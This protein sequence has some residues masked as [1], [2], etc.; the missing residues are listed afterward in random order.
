MPPDRSVLVVDLRSGVAACS[1][2][3]AGQGIRSGMPR[4]EAEA[5]APGAAVVVRDRG[6]EARRFEPLVSAVEALVPRVEVAEPG[7]MFVPV[8]GAVRYYGGEDALV[9]RMS[10]EL[11]ALASGGLIGLADGPFAARWAAAAAG[12]RT[13]RV[14]TDTAGFLAGLD[15]SLLGDADLASVF[16]W[17][18]VTTLGELARLP[19]EALASR[20]GRAGLLAHRLASGEDRMVDPRTI[21]A[22][23]AVEA[24][25]EEPLDT[26]DRAG[27]AARSLAARLVEGLGR[28][29]IAPHRVLVEVETEVGRV[30]SRVWRSVDPFTEEALAERVRW[31]LRAWLDTSGVGSGVVRLRL[32]PS[33]L[34]GAGRQQVFFDEVDGRIEAERALG[35]VQALVGPDAVLHAAPQGGRLPAEQVVWGRWGEDVPTPDRDPEAPWPGATPTPTP[36]LV[37]PEPIPLH[38][39]WE[40]GFPVAVRLRA[41]REPVLSWSGPWRLM[42]RWWKGEE[43]VDRYQLVTSAG[44]MLCVVCDGKAYLAGVYD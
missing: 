34:S 38:V 12:P 31:Q 13:P 37:P 14:V 2:E 28:E 25:Y 30:Y 36:A 20:F 23:L 40:A 29:G 17:L 18:G 4:R 15:V 35:R 1:P 32:D 44:A 27:F 8:Q 16:R 24:R 7:M 5:L 22:T 41:R 19:R 3:L 26:L 6:E 11:D 9:E 21:P 42:G 33:D 10:K 39:E 43:P